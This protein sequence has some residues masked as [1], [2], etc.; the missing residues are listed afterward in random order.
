MKTSKIPGVKNGTNRTKLIQIGRIQTMGSFY[1]VE[2]AETLLFC[3]V[4][5]G[6]VEVVGK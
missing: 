4:A 2:D 3:I 5:E 6:F 1:V